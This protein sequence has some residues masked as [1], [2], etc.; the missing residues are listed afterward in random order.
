MLRSGRLTQDELEKQLLLK[1][2]G[3]TGS[4]PAPAAARP[5]AV[6]PRMTSCVSI[7]PMVL[8]LGALCRFGAR[9]FSDFAQNSSIFSSGVFAGRG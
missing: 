2:A 3:R 4:P 5:G 1:H 7:S 9:K 6:T 8:I